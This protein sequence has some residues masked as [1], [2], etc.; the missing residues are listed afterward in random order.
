MNR[1]NSLAG[2]LLV[3]VVSVAMV[4][5]AWAAARIQRT[6]TRLGSDT[7]SRTVV[8]FDRPAE[9]Q[10][11]LRLINEDM[12][13]EAVALAEDYLESLDSAHGYLRSTPIDRRYDALN[14]LCAAYTKA[15]ELAEAIDRCSRAIEIVPSR[16]SARN[17]RGTAYFA[18]GDYVQALEDYRRALF[19][20]YQL[21]EI[22][23]VEHNIDLAESRLAALD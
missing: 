8:H 14:A 22:A 12:I 1:L 4:G 20:A 19:Y 16:W 3:A 13:D 15:G 5:Q 11:V 17:N 18:Q 21:N 23:T 9:I 10:R 2:V 7:T 6:G